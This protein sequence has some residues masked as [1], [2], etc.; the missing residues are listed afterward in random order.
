MSA[1]SPAL[2]TS[3]LPGIGRPLSDHEGRQL[4]NYIELLTKWQKT[5]RLIGSVELPWIVENVLVHSFCFLETLPVDLRELA[6]VGS[7]AGLPGIPIAVVRPDLRVTLIE[8][9]QRRISFL[10]TVVR[11]LGLETVEVVG[12]R[13]ENLGAAFTHRFDAV[14]MRCAGEVSG[15]V[16][17]GFR[18]V[19]HGGVVVVS[20]HSTAS[21]PRQG[22]AVVVRSPSGA[23][24]T[25]HRFR[26]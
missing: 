17:A 8:A 7:G 9:R 5:H 10:S 16:D 23:L 13:V 20:S 12:E 15:M 1:L 6:D 11:E 21:L 19:R 26:K 2:F 22:E 18:V 4:Y 24:R 25:F 3:P 14:V